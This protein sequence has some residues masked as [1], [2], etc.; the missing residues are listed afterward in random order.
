MLPSVPL[1]LCCTPISP[2][3]PCLR[4]SWHLQ[5]RLCTQQWPSSHHIVSEATYTILRRLT[6]KADM[7]QYEH[8]LISE[9]STHVPL[10]VLPSLQASSSLAR[11]YI[12][13][14][15]PYSRRPSLQG[16]NIGPYD[17]LRGAKLASICPHSA[18]ALRTHLLRSPEALST[19][20]LE[21]AERF[22]R[23]REVE[24]AVGH[25]LGDTTPP[26]DRESTERTPIVSRGEGPG[27]RKRTT[28]A[29]RWSKARWEEEWEGGLATD[30]AK[31]LRARRVKGM[32]RRSTVRGPARPRLTPLCTD[33]GVGTMNSPVCEDTPSSA[34]H[35]DPLHLPSLLAFSFSLLG[36]LKARIA[37]M[38]TPTRA[39]TAVAGVG[40]TTGSSRGHVDAGG[41]TWAL[42]GVFCAGVGMG[43]LLSRTM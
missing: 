20:R 19:L 33:V 2:L 8:K 12:T 17:T 42:V 18:H 29:Q 25:V 24:R 32:E 5:H 37:Q 41:M 23:W 27:K 7:T 13:H 39:N 38:F 16:L 26:S 34:A 36:P 43:V 14:Q 3:M 22:M 21:A 9:L 1:C 28:V 15:S 40:G 10:V 31:T 4:V 30:V 6:I 35:F 11:T